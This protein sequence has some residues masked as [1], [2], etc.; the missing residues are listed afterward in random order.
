MVEL[1]TVCGGQEHHGL[2][3][4]RQLPEAHPQR[5]SQRHQPQLAGHLPAEGNTFGTYINQVNEV[6]ESE[7]N[8]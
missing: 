8:S 4:S 7:H 5:R 1:D 2:A 3:A 6:F